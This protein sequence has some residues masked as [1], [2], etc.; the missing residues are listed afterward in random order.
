MIRSASL[1]RPLRQT[2]LVLV[3][4]TACLWLAACDSTNPVAPDSQPPGNGGGG[5]GTG[6]FAIELTAE[7]SSIMVGTTTPATIRVN[8]RRSD[9]QPAAD[10]TRCAI[11]T[12]LGSFDASRAVTLVNATLAG[13]VATASLYPGDATGT[14][15]ILAQVDTTVQR[16]S[17]PIQEF[18]RPPFYLTGIQPNS[19]T[20][21][22]DVPV[23]ITGAGFESPVRVTFGTVVGTD[24][25]VLS[26]STIRVTT[27]RP[28]TPVAVG[29]TLIV[30]VTVTNNID[31]AEPVSDTLPGSF[32]YVNGESL[33]R[34]VVFSVDPPSGS[35]NGGETVT[36]RGD[37]FVPP[38]QVIFGIRPATGGFEG[39]EASVTSASR[40]RLSVRTP[41]ATGLGQSLFNRQVD[42]LVRNRDTG[43]QTIAGG[44]FRYVSDDIFISDVQPREA[45]YHGG[46]RVTITGQGFES[47]VQ[48]RFGGS[49]QTVESVSSTRIVART[50]PV[51]V[52]NCNP[53]LGPV[54]VTN[55]QSAQTVTSD[56]VFSY[57]ADPPLLS[58]ISPASGLFDVSIPVRIE[59]TSF[60]S[61]VLVEINNVRAQVSNTSS[62]RIDATVP[63]FTGTFEEQP[64]DD[65]NDG[66][67]GNRFLPKAVDVKV[68]NTTTGCLD[69]LVQGYSYQPRDTTCRGDGRLDPPIANFTFT[70]VDPITRLVQFQDASGGGQPTSWQWTFGDSGSTQNT[71]TQRNPS[72]AFSAP[73]T[74][75]VVLRVANASGSNQASRDVTVP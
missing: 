45:S 33:D 47:Q 43:F 48:V 42:V 35:N 68:T 58:R 70:I 46:D 50:I 4:L 55:L 38:V 62:T 28:A 23:T 5:S 41:A 11:S 15:N 57:S 51:S 63:T 12:S 17:V 26:S 9:G 40:T 74:Y 37:G 29:D 67:R 6:A 10:G 61:P 56:I 16:L 54:Q 53:P 36:I 22:G 3:A 66:Q 72:H 52:T 73:G 49:V 21:E 65:N 24:A 59:G 14:A 25:Q 13:G 44:A 31:E 20:A 39:V 69:T 18:E 1:S 2:G 71:S 27:P 64:C 8:V 60:E 19:G 32:T 75:T 7:P 30:N 34:P